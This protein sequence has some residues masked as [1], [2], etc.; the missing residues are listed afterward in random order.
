MMT[1]DDHHDPTIIPYHFPWS[2]RQVNLL[3]APFVGTFRRRRIACLRAWQ[4]GHRGEIH[5][6]S[7]G[8]W[9][10]LEQNHREIIGKHR[11]ML[12][13]NKGFNGKI[14]YQWWILY[15]HVRLAGGIAGKKRMLLSFWDLLDVF[16]HWKWWFHG[17]W[18]WNIMGCMA[19][20]KIL[21]TQWHVKGWWSSPPFV[22]MGWPWWP[23]T[24]CFR[25]RP[26]KIRGCLLG[27][28]HYVW[29]VH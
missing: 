11:E 18:W 22:I 17:I 8:K 1:P 4:A 23:C 29:N 5:G 16:N 3:N 20:I 2:T 19:E 15:C 21:V 10:F 12:E 9:R 13:L 27:P 6:N 26:W 25:H 28:S 7:R 14:N 24:M